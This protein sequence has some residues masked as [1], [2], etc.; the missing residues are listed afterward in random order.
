VEVPDFGQRAQCHLASD[1]LAGDRDVQDQCIELAAGLREAQALLDQVL[2][3]RAF[4]R[5]G[6]RALRCQFG[7]WNT[8]L[9]CRSAAVMVLSSSASSTRSRSAKSRLAWR[10]RARSSAL[11]TLR[12]LAKCGWAM[13]R[14]R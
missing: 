5:Q 8:R 14:S 1:G 9:A 3:Q 2:R 4:F 12:A 11:R 7:F 13:R 10:S 6:H